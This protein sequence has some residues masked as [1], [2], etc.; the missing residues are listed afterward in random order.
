[1]TIFETVYQD[2]NVAAVTNLVGDIS[3]YV[4]G[5]RTSFPAVLYEIPSQEYERL[6]SGAYRILSE[7]EVT[8][9]ARSVSEAEAVAA[10]VIDSVID[11]TCNVIQTVTRDYEEGHDED[12]VGLFM[13]TINYTNIGG[14]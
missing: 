2:L 7:V 11:A 1:M 5:R 8:C 3:P 14:A 4:R 10:A 13:V 9:I 6:S 12:S